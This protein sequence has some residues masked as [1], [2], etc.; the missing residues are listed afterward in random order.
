MSDSLGRAIDQACNRFEQVWQAALRKEPGKEA[1]RIEDFLGDLPPS[2]RAEAVRELVALDIIYRRQLGQQPTAEDYRPRFPELDELD[3]LLR[4]PAGSGGTA[5]STVNFGEPRTRSLQPGQKVSYFGDY[6]LLEEIAQGGMGVVYKARQVSLDR[7]VALK[8]IRAGEFASA[9]DVQRFKQ[10]A[11]AAAK[12]DHPHIVPIFEVSEHE[13][14]HYYAMKLIDGGSLHKVKPAWCLS[15]EL[16]RSEIRRRQTKIATLLIAVARAVHHA[17]QHS[18]IHRDLKPANILI[19]AAGAPHVTDF[20]LAKKIEADSAMTQT[21]AIVGTASYMSPQQANGEPIT[22]QA[23][24]YGLGAVLYELLTGRP[25][26]KAKTPLDTL[27]EVRE[28]DAIRPSKLVPQVDRDLETICLKCLEK[29]PER[30]YGSAET[31]V[32]DLQRWQRGEPIEARRAGSVERAA[33]WVRRHPAPTALAAVSVVALVAVVGFG[34][35]QSYNQ[36]LTDANS[37]LEI[38]NGRLENAVAALADSNGK[39]E[40]AA[41]DLKSSLG[42][43][44]IQKNEAENQRMLARAEEKKARQYMYV[45]RLALAKRA[46]EEKEPARLVQ[47]LRSLVPENSD[48]DDVRGWEWHYLW[49]KYHG[50]NLGVRAHQGAVTALAHSPNGKTLATAGDDRTIKLWDIETGKMLGVLRGHTDRVTS[51][52]WSSDGESIVSGSVDRTVKLWHVASGELRHSLDKHLGAVTSVRFDPVNHL[53][54]SASEDGLVWLWDSRTVRAMREIPAPSPK[55]TVA[56]LAF[57]PDGKSLA[58]LGK[59]EVRILDLE[60]STVTASM[61]IEGNPASVAFCPSGKWLAVGT[62]IP[63]GL[64]KDKK[65]P[66]KQPLEPNR[67]T[68][69]VEIYQLP[70]RAPVAVIVQPEKSMTNMAFLSDAAHLAIA[71][72][73]R[74]VTIWTAVGQQTQVYHADSA[75]HVVGCLPDGSLCAGTVAGLVLI[76][77]SRTVEA[78]NLIPDGGGGIIHV[79]F[80]AT[81]NRIGAS[82]GAEAFIWDT[83]TGDVISRFE[84]GFNFDRIAFGPANNLIAGVPGTQLRDASTGDVRVVL[85]RPAG[86]KTNIRPLGTAFSSDG[87]WIAIA[88]AFEFCAIWEA[89]TGEVVHAFAM[90]QWASCVAFSPDGKLFSAGTGHG[91]KLPRG[92]IKVW[93]V[94]MGREAIRIGNEIEEGVWSIAFSPNGKVLAAATGHLHSKRGT[95]TGEI[96]VWNVETGAVVYSMR[97]HKCSVWQIA[98]SSDSKRLASV[99]GPSAMTVNGPSEVR[100]WDLTTGELLWT[101]VEPVR[102]SGVAFSPDGRRLAYA[103][104]RRVMLLDG[105]PLAGAIAHAPVPDEQ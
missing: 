65:P 98:F 62:N 9:A 95:N 35:A 79:V 83:N 71:S 76:W 50:E 105:T 30:R 18:I 96:W 17:H 44:E 61:P 75:V 104:W 87:K 72:L 59:R 11:E 45:A 40:I 69:R 97:G 93:D 4:E 90:P 101:F 99:S 67:P 41:K 7:L 88:N 12:L 5:D 3:E 48:Q 55:E 15:P 8:M 77:K 68:T 43:V 37:K 39:L 100:I 19:D 38:A 26:F 52:S 81:G 57:H 78:K 85:K 46:E 53:V 47:I 34:V 24:V 86:F 31:L 58:I 29:Q 16:D 28:Q 20:G 10:E 82:G 91:Q 54:A 23:D 14:Q 6:E 74:T 32:E 66:A 2:A 73:D 49:R 64:G 103:G 25:P 63:P 60:S 33:K 102:I 22:T 70:Q 27:I 42:Q 80:D 89:A 51:V 21:G 36:D 56:S 84:G 94:A 92:T 13:G 1:P